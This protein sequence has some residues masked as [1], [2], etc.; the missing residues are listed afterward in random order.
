M[1]ADVTIAYRSAHLAAESAQT[2][3][4]VPTFRRP[5]HLVATLD[6]LARQQGVAPFAVIVMENDAEGRAGADAARRWFEA[7]S[8][9]AAVAGGLVVVAH[10]RGNCHAYNAGWETAL[11][12]FPGCRQLAVLDDDELADA[13]WLGN[14][15]AVAAASGAD[16]VGGPQVPVFDDPAL[17]PWARHPAFQPHYTQSGPVPILYS[18][19]NVLI[20]RRVIEAM[21]RPFL[22]PAFNF[23]GG[24]DSDFYRRCRK[25]G[26][27]FAWSAEAKVLETVPSRRAEFSWLNARSLRNGAISAIIERRE[28]PG[29]RSRLRIVGKSLALLAA[30]P[31]RGVRLGAATGS[32]TIGLYHLQVA[33][34]RLLAEFGLVNEQYRNPEAN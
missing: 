7:L 31:F 15:R 5:E 11:Q 4:T 29:W 23:I 24:G 25:A 12:A 22:D 18:S 17:S 3:V 28:A 10:R 20:A 1:P 6:S 21:P 34:G 9:D 13:G 14:L 19:G 33:I 16:L 8:A 32:A 2:V 26:F 30:S 27:R